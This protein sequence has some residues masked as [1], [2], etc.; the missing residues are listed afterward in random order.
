[1]NLMKNRSLLFVTYII[2]KLFYKTIYPNKCKSYVKECKNKIQETCY[3]CFCNVYFIDMQQAQS[4]MIFANTKAIDIS[5]L[6]NNANIN[7][8]KNYIICF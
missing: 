5:N 1:M 7:Y 4:I 8:I 6:V 2:V 3:D